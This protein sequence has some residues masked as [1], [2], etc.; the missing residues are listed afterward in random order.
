MQRVNSADEKTANEESSNQISG[1]HRRGTHSDLRIAWPFAKRYSRR[2]NRYARMRTRREH[3]RL[4]QNTNRRLQIA[5]LLASIDS[6]T[7]SHSDMSAVRS[8]LRARQQFG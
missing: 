5:L 4:T 2:L 7:C 3:L 1:A 8:D 6:A